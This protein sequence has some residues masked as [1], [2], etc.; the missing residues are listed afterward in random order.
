M[1]RA[2]NPKRRRH[3]FRAWRE[4]RGLSR[5]ELAQRLGI[6]AAILGRI[7]RM[8][9]GYSQEF[10]EGCADALRTDPASLVMR[11]PGD[12]DGIWT[13][14]ET[15]KPHRLTRNETKP[16]PNVWKRKRSPHF[17]RAWREHRGLTPEQLAELV[18]TSA[19]NVCR[20]ETLRDG[21]TQNFLEACAE[22]LKTDPASLISHLPAG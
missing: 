21:Y 22:A 17:I 6:S 8:Q 3:F 18:G 12:P 2:G 19:A 5:D 9:Q 1:P 11:D 7:E 13:I 20:I 14:W 15:A 10:L 4:Y 16:V